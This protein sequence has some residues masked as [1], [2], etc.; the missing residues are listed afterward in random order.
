MKDSDFVSYAKSF[1]TEINLELDRIVCLLKHLGNP[2]KNMKYIHVTGTNGKGSVCAFLESMLVSAGFKTGRFSSPELI[3][4]NETIRVNKEN[5]SDRRLEYLLS[6]TAAAAEKVREETGEMPS[7]FEAMCAA[8]FLYFQNEKCD[9]CILEV[10]MG[11]AGD[12]TN[13]IESAE[14]CILTQIDL[15]HTKYLGNTPEEIARVKAGI[16]K[17][18]SQAVTTSKNEGVLDV[19]EGR[20]RRA[21]AVLHTVAPAKS[22]GFDEIYEKIELGGREVQLSLGGTVQTDNASLAIRAAQLLNISEKDIIF[23]L[24]NSENPARF[25][26]VADSLYF[27]GAHNLGGAAALRSGLDRYMPGREK[28]FVMGVMADKDF[29]KMLGILNDGRSDFYFVAVEDNPRAMKA[30]DMERAARE[31]GIS[32]T[33]CGDINDALKRAEGKTVVV[34]GSLYLYRQFKWAWGCE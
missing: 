21:G 22:M 30:E 23:G 1:Q 2:H 32:G 31:A 27:D 29:Q 10:G 26:K 16:I 9:Y 20:C 15:D 33:V 11:G 25:E 34:C 24:E 28:A 17:P 4:K 8:A 6:V 12:A 7:P 14:I 13:V 18:G 5:I 3:I 19:I